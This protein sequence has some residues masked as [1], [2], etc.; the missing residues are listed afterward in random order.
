MVLI[1]LRVSDAFSM[2]RL[3]LLLA[4]ED[5]KF[6]C[7]F[8]K[9]MFVFPAMVTMSISAT[10]MYRNLAD[11]FFHPDECVIL[12]FHHSPYSLRLTSH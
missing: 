6:L 2:V 11:F 7:V 9:Q 10:R 8:E 3:C 5:S 12:P 1:S 4:T